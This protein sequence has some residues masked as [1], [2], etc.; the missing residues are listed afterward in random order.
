MQSKGPVAKPRFDWK[1]SS[2]VVVGAILLAVAI[3][4]SILWFV[5]SRQSVA[6]LTT[7]MTKEAQHGRIWACPNQKIG[8]YPFTVAVSCTDLLFQ[9][10]VFG[11]RLTGTVHGFRAT[12]P[13]LRTD[14]MFAEMDP[15]FAAKSSDGTLDVAAQWTYL[16][17]DLE[18]QPETFERISLI[19]DG[20]VLQG[21]VGGT[22]VIQGKAADFHSYVVLA[23]NRHDYA[24]DFMFGFNDGSFPAL[25]SF[26]DTQLPVSASF[27]GVISQADITGVQT[28]TD[29]LEKWRTANGRVDITSAR[30]K[31]GTIS[32]NATGSLDLDDQHRVKGKLDTEF[33]GLDKALRHLNVDP[34][35]L[36]VG[37]VLSGILGNGGNQGATAGR[38]KLPLTVSDGRVSIGPVR[39]SIEVPPLY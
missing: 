13:L 33:G 6:I 16:A 8:G 36:T 23:G 3:G 30:L 19:G 1:N 11:K 21:T 14:G 28:L 27:G 38:L 18:G 31:S 35:L 4:W 15:P 26:L 10:E 2:L 24:Y 7:W 29:F 32:F 34:A 5:A 37:Q 20:V 39:T 12:A 25:N 17:L 9:G 22:D